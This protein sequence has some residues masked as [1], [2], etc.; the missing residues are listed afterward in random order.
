M[1]LLLGFAGWRRAALFHRSGCSKK[2]HRFLVLN[3]GTLYML[4]GT[5]CY[6]PGTPCI[7]SM[8]TPREKNLRLLGPVLG[9]CMLGNGEEMVEGF[10]G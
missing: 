1:W 4:D 7:S 2:M 3:M 9:R 6:T 5:V 8:A 10:C